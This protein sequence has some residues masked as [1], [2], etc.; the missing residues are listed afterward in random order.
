MVCDACQK[1]LASFSTLIASWSIA[2][3][4]NDDEDMKEDFDD[5]EMVQVKK[6]G[7]DELS[8]SNTNSSMGNIEVGDGSKSSKKTKSKNGQ[9]TAVKIKT[10]GDGLSDSC[11]S[12]SV[13]NKEIKKEPEGGAEME[14]LQLKSEEV[15]I[16]PEDEDG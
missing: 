16:K 5:F 3:G 8:D 1:S 11:E 9:A 13:N 4:W 12:A 2:N 15:N 10:E 7:F 14:D 6:E